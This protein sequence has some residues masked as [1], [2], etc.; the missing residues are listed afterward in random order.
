MK[1]EPISELDEYRI[2]HP[3]L[4]GTPAGASYGAFRILLRTC[5]LK[6]ISSGSCVDN[7]EADG[8]EHVS[9]SIASRCPTWD[10]MC[11]VKRLFWGEDETVVEF[12]PKRSMYVN[13][14]PYCL[15]MWKRADREY[16]LPPAMFVG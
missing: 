16:E 12:H 2:V 1:P 13:K 11:F 15:H 8:W 5:V 6:V 7:P 9:V 3:T 14:M 10:E 4:G